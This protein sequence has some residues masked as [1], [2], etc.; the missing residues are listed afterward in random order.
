MGKTVGEL[1]S[2]IRE[3]MQFHGINA[4]VRRLL[5]AN[6]DFILNLL[7]SAL[8]AFYDHMSD[9][10]QAAPFFST[11]AHVERARAG[12]L[13]HWENILEGRFDEVYLS[14]VRRIGET[15]YRIG[16]EPRWYIGG[17]SFLL[18]ALLGRIFAALSGPEGLPCTRIVPLQQAVSRVMLL[19]MDYVIETYLDAKYVFV[20]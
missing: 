5:M 14:S 17:Y 20:A 8:D 7:P 18:S 2:D 19:D 4:E 11:T 12:Q 15:H 10:P 16:L 13:R 1:R 6:R 9:M 3:R